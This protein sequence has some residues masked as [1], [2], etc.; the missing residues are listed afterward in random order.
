MGLISYIFGSKK[1]F[2][3]PYLGEF[4]S[5]RIKGNNTSKTYYWIGETN[6]Y[7]NDSADCVTSI[8]IN[9]N[10]TSPYPNQLNFISDLLKNWKNDYLLKIENEISN[11]DFFKKQELKNWKNEFFLAAI[12]TNSDKGLDFELNLESK[13]NQ[14]YPTISIAVKNGIISKVELY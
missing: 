13:Q 8:F 11:Q 14:E 7:Y 5:Q 6:L 10:N 3:H 2:N 9:G 12:Y 4:I 1:V